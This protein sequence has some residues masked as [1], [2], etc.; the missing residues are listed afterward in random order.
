MMQ[1][2]TGGAEEE[3]TEKADNNTRPTARAGTPCSDNA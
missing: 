1:L 2:T 3:E